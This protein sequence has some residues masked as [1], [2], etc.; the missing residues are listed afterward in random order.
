[1][2]KFVANIVV[3]III[4]TFLILYVIARIEPNYATSELC[5]FDGLIQSL[6]ASFLFVIF[7]FLFL[8]PSI[9][10]SSNIAELPDMDNAPSHLRFKVVN[11]SL[12]GVYDLQVNVYEFRSINTSGPDIKTVLL[13]HYEGIQKGTG[14]LQSAFR[15]LFSDTKLN[16]V[17]FRFRKLLGDGQAENDEADKKIKKILKSSSS[18]IE[19]HVSVR[20]GLSGLMG[21]SVKRYH[22]QACIKKGIFEHGFKTGVK[23]S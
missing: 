1:M 23:P 8:K 19:I 10:I 13:C 15:A 14:H 18:Y 20:H 16:A 5:R 12:F 3:L 7:L 6:I 11:S 9:K 4:I 17:Q 21:N 22:N 2:V